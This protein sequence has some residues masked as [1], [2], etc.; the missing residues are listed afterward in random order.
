MVRSALR[1]TLLV[2]LFATLAAAAP[3]GAIQIGI[4]EQNGRMFYDPLFAPL[5]LH[6]ARVVVPWNLA[7]SK[8]KVQKPYLQWLAGAALTGVEP[9]VAFN[10]VGYVRNPKG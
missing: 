4:S 7:L 2:S 3:A 9:H 10:A 5:H 6:Y 8:A 1:L